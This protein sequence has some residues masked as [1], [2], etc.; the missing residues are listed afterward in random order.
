MG[1]SAVDCGALA[2]M[3]SIGFTIGGRVFELEPDQVLSF[4][5]VAYIYN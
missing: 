1:E 2:S 4:R 5:K 3:P